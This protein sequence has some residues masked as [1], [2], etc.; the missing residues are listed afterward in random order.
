MN[1]ELK[2]THENIIKTINE[3]VIKR[4][5]TLKNFVKFLYTIKDINIISLNGEWGSGKT[6]F[7]HQT[8][9]IIKNLNKKEKEIEKEIQPFISDFKNIHC[10]NI[11]T[12][13]QLMPI[14]FNAWEYDSNNDPLI[15]LIYS[16]IEQNPN[17]KDIENKNKSKKDKIFKILSNFKIVLSHQ[18]NNIS[19]IGIEL[20]YNNTSE[21]NELTEEVYSIEKT[22]QIFNK[23]IDEIIVK[24]VNKIVVF[25]D[26]LDRCKPDFAVKLLERVKHFFNNEHFIFIFSTNL[27]E[28]QHTIKKF[29]GEGIDGYSYLDKFFDIQFSLRT[30][31]IEDYIQSKNV[32]YFG[33]ERYFECLV[34]EMSLLYNFSL[35]KC[36]RYINMI[37]LIYESVYISDVSA[38]AICILFPILLAIKIENINIYNKIISGNGESELKNIIMKSNVII[39]TFNNYFNVDNYE[40]VLGFDFH[41]L[42]HAIFIKKENF[43]FKEIKIGNKDIKYTHEKE[44]LMEALTFLSDIVI[45]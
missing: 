29:Y 11:K 9:E 33:T 18:I 28:L 27:N 31:N 41:E 37:S 32:I 5:K 13:N 12:K 38:L 17:L 10:N 40:G 15:A 24:P 43:N 26:E 19:S 8:M 21:K 3:D 2:P 6:F 39:K 25:I 42:Y 4:N 14:Y 36:N 22:K 44:S 23:L 34:K 20:Q 16:I 1:F 45:L 7:I 35:R 30:T